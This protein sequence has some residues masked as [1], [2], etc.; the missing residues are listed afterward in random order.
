[1]S[2]VVAGTINAALLPVK[3]TVSTAVNAT[4]PLL[5][6]GGSGINQLAD[7][8]V[9]GSTSV[10]LPTT[11]SAPQSLTQDLDANFVGSVIRSNTIDVNL[12]STGN[13]ISPIYFAA[14]NPAATVTAPTVNSVTG[15]STTGYTVTGTADPNVNVEIRNQAGTVVGTATADDTGAFTVN[16]ATGSAAA[17]ENLN[18]VVI[19]GDTESTATGFQTP[20]DPTATVQTPV[21]DKITGSTTKGYEVTGTAEAG[22]TIEVR[23]TDGTVIGTGTTAPNGDYIVTLAPGKATAAEKFKCSSD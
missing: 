11:V 20:A 23:S 12:I 4:L 2:A 5:Q 16:I 6:A 8:S 14:S 1:L 13:G 19:N 17:N 18:A 7:A 22:T 3:G 15:T 9:L 10:T 21:V